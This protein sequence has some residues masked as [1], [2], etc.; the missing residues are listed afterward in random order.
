MEII[1]I[2]GTAGKQVRYQDQVYTL[3]EDIYY[4]EQDS[5]FDPVEPRAQVKSSDP[6]KL[7][8]I[9]WYISA[10]DLDAWVSTGDYSANINGILCTDI[11]D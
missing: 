8:E 3:A 4:P 11:D 9:Y 2:T 10:A 1:S 7:L 6:T 5:E